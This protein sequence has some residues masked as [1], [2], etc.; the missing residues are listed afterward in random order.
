MVEPVVESRHR[1]LAGLLAVEP[2]S[3]VVDL[4]CGTGSSLRFV[5]PAT[6]ASP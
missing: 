5:V 2:G 4:G 1:W 6:P 3:R